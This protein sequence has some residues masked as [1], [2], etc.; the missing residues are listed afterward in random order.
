M[1]IGQRP[2]IWEQKKEIVPE[3]HIINFYENL[4]NQNLCFYFTK[5]LRDE[6]KFSNLENLKKQ[7][8]KDVLE[9]GK[10]LG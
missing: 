9:A 3:C 8:K 1:N 10:I 2:S 7:I 6:K 4:Y 5:K